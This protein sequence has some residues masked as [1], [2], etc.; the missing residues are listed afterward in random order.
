MYFFSDVM[1]DMSFSGG[2]E[3]LAAGKDVEG[4][5]EVVR[6]LSPCFYLVPILFSVAHGRVF[7]WRSATILISPLP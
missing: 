1:G 3:T 7:R 6:H 5:M 2:F 4:W